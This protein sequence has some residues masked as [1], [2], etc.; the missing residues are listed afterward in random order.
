MQETAK[1]FT[2]THT[3]NRDIIYKGQKA[4][5]Q[6]IKYPEFFCKAGY[7]HDQ[8]ILRLVSKLNKF[9]KSAS[10]RLESYSSNVFARKAYASMKKTDS[11]KPCGVFMNCHVAFCSGDFVSIITDIS[12]FDGRNTKC[13]RISHTWSIEKN[14]IVPKNALIDISPSSKKYIKQYISDCVKRNQSNPFFN[15]YGDAVKLFQK[16]FRLDNL[17]LVPNGIAFYIDSGILCDVKYGP[18]VFVLP[19]DKA[20]GIFK[21]GMS[22]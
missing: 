22:Q 9:Y 14:S 21:V 4:V 11:K 15:Y 5:S 7:E 16:H 12:G 2:K 10:Q 18:C 17:Y 6:N 19:F 1:I 8:N 20:D 13:Q 3:I